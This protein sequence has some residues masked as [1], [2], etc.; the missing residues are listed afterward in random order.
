[1]DENLHD[2]FED[3]TFMEEMNDCAPK[4]TKEWIFPSSEKLSQFLQEERKNLSNNKENRIQMMENGGTA[5]IQNVYTKY[6]IEGI[7]SNPLGFYLFLK[8][9]KNL[10]NK[11]TREESLS[12][13]GLFHFLSKNSSSATT[14]G[15]NK[16]EK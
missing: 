16:K 8:Y 13:T 7:C 14:I 5:L 15:K 2:T 10:A 11:A 6:S 3:W 9:C 12:S 1:M 4:A